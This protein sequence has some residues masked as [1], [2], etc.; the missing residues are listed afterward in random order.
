MG[1]GIALRPGSCWLP[2]GWVGDAA[3]AQ[4]IPQLV[5]PFAAAVRERVEHIHRYPGAIAQFE[6]A[7]ADEVRTLYEAAARGR[8][9]AERVGAK[10]WERPDMLPGFL[11]AFD[12]LLAYIASDARI[13]GSTDT[14]AVFPSSR[15]FHVTFFSQPNGNA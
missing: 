5:G 14:E 8:A 3:A 15:G 4:I 11:R 10:A 6:H 1:T 13:S 9:S 12:E 2:A 7:S